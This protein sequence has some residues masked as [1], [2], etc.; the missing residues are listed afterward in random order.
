VN[1]DSEAVS[2]THRS[3][4]RWSSSRT[5]GGFSGLWPGGSAHSSTATRSLPKLPVS[6]CDFRH[7]SVMGWSW[8]S[9]RPLRRDH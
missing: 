3:S 2:I 4:C 1:P 5:A 8:P 9:V 6:V 7:K